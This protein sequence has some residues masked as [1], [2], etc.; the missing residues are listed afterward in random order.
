M[1]LS[2]CKIAL[3][4]LLTGQMGSGLYGNFTCC[5]VHECRA[6]YVLQVFF[7]ISPFRLAFLAK[8]AFYATHAY[9]CARENAM[10]QNNEISSDN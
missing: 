3:G 1:I 8:I 5:R 9:V 2:S 7:C 6:D 4:S 10:E